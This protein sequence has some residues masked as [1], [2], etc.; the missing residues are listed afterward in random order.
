MLLLNY[1]SHIK[2]TNHFLYIIWYLP[3]SVPFNT[4]MATIDV[5]SLYTNI[6][7]LH[8]HSALEHSFNQYILSFLT[9]N[10][11]SYPNQPIH[12]SSTSL[13]SQHYLLVKANHH[14]HPYGPFLHK[15]VH[16]LLEQDFFHSMPN[17]PSLWLPFLDD[18]FLLWPW[19]QLPHSIQW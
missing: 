17:K 15:P 13:N 2:D 1:S 4:I 3:I 7:Y 5:P 18:I 8:G 12:C 16:G 6:P 11:I 14:G 19:S 10:L 9:L